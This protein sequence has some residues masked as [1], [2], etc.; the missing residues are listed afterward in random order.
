MTKVISR[1]AITVVA[2]FTTLWVLAHMVLVYL[3]GSWAISESNSTV[4][5]IEISICSIIAIFALA[6]LVRDWR[7]AMKW[8][9]RGR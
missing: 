3:N 9:R 4:L 8:A 1:L 7:R 5:I 6:M 2:L